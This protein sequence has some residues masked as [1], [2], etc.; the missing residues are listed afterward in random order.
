MAKVQKE[1]LANL[2]E[3]V[4][5][6]HSAL[7]KGGSEGLKLELSTCKWKNP[8]GLSTI[9]SKWDNILVELKNVAQK[10]KKGNPEE[11]VDSA[12]KLSKCIADLQVFILGIAAEIG[13]FVPG[14]I[15]MVCSLALAIG[16]FAVGDIPGGFLNLIG[17]IPGAKLA[18]YIPLGPLKN[19]VLKFQS[20]L[21]TRWG[22]KV[23]ALTQKAARNCE[24]F[25]FSERFDLYF[26]N[27]L[28]NLKKQIEKVGEKIGKEVEKVLTGID[29]G[30]NIEREKLKEVKS[31]EYMLGQSS[32]WL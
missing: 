11:I 32:S 28:K 29:D 18:K 8:F 27:T 16:C 3:I 31:F 12:T 15:G 23:S 30:W 21:C 24:T 4:E 1:I 2:G 17:A 6:F 22:H 26:T 20:E 5:Q 9:L 25:R 7:A 14:P 19:S 10:L 13:S